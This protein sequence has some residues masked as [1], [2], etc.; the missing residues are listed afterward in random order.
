MRKGWMEGRRVDVDGWLRVPFELVEY[1]QRQGS[2]RG[3]NVSC[4]SL[5]Q[6]S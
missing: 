2:T 5:A 4:H 3:S 6:I 1:T